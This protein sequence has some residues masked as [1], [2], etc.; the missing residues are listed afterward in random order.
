MSGTIS[1]KDRHEGNTVSKVE[2]KLPTIT[3]P[4]SQP[5]LIGFITSLLSSGMDLLGAMHT[6]S[7]NH[8]LREGKKS[9][10]EEGAQLLSDELSKASTPQRVTIDIVDQR[11]VGF[12]RP[13]TDNY[14]FEDTYLSISEIVRE[15]FSKDAAMFLGDDHQPTEEQW[16]AI[17]STSLATCTIG[18]AGTGKTYV[19]G[20]RVILLNR[21]LG[22]P[23]DE[24]TVLCLTKDCRLDV[25]ALI[26]DLFARWGEMLSDDQCYHLVKT[27]RGALLGHVRELPDMEGVLPFDLL[28]DTTDDE[29]GRPFDMRLTNKQVA[30]LGEAFNQ[31]YVTDP[32]FAEAI[33]TLLRSN[34]VLDEL[35]ADD[36]LV[37]RRAA[38]GWQ[39]AKFDL[40]IAESMQ[41]IWSKAGV[42]PLPGFRSEITSDRVR[43]HDVYFNGFVPALNVHVVLGFDRSE[44]RTL[45]R[46]IGIA[47]ELFKE[48][49]IKKT[50]LQAFSPKPVIYLESYAQARALSS[51]LEFIDHRAP[52]FPCLLKGET[53]AYPIAEALYHC[54]TL[55][56]TMGLDIGTAV[57]EMNFMAG[58]N[59]VHFFSALGIFWRSFESYLLAQTTPSFTFN[60]LFNMFGSAGAT[61]IRAIPN[62][63]LRGMRHVLVDEVQDITSP[64][65]EWIKACLLENRRRSLRA[66]AKGNKLMACTLFLTGDDYQTAHGTQGATPRYLL[67][68]ES[69][70]RC[71][72]PAKIIMGANFRSHQNIIDAAHSMVMGIPAVSGFAPLS[73]DKAGREAEEPVLIYHLD[74]V[75]LTD[76]L[77]QH[78]DKGEDILIL[79]ANPEDFKLMEPEINA[80]LER[81][82]LNTKRRVRVRACQ[83]AKGLEAH[84]VFI[85]GDFIAP[86]TSWSKNQIFTLADRQ[87]GN[88]QSP[89]DTIQQHELFRLAHIGI[90]RARRHCYWLIRPEQEGEPAQMRASIRIQAEGG[91]LKDLRS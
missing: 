56:E 87:R 4:D 73:V 64:I 1:R 76:L 81:D 10:K 72:K 13:H 22:V 19:M 67:N 18:I 49:A 17:L 62:V 21:Y 36:P 89:F 54:G 38:A 2:R 27:P 68:Y 39:Q 33:R 57:A 5:A 44:E 37:V 80:I 63:A 8:G 83:R 61:N 91:Y 11:Q 23:L 12:K 14:V 50:M 88:G 35:D 65:G 31:C 69:E 15:R 90:T 84:T 26:R 66:A 82:K 29:D 52:N 25:I 85:L 34:S 7:Y 58:D 51:T 71:Q 28:S 41:S 40:D 32:E 79:A 24:I 3:H 74:A 16:R 53:R 43:G 55:M 47:T 20:M 59:D 60:R 75:L 46:G 9:A 42:W 45:T 30:V 48:C 77:N 70:F 6:L 78:Y 86:T